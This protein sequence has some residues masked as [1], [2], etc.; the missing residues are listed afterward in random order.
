MSSTLAFVTGEQY[1]NKLAR[2]IMMVV[3]LC[4]SSI[5]TLFQGKELNI[6]R[7][8]HSWSLLKMIISLKTLGGFY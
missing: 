8:L 4:K 2:I 3:L 7:T 5:V 6:N 1:W